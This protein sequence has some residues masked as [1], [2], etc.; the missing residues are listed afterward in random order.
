MCDEDQQ[1]TRR[2]LIQL[3]GLLAGSS[4]CA[5]RQLQAAAAQSSAATTQTKQANPKV[6]IGYI[7]ITDATPLLVAYQNKLFQQQGLD[8]DPPVLFRS[9]A[10]LIEAFLSG[11]VNVIH[12]L[13]PMAVWTRFSSRFPAKV[14][15]W[16]HIAGSALTVQRHINRLEQLGGQYLAIPFWYSVHN[17]VLQAMLRHAGLEVI[18]KPDQKLSRKQVGLIVLSPSD[19]PPALVSAQIAGYLVAEPFNAM[20]E[21]LKIGKILRFSGDVWKQHAC[22]VVF[23][24][25]RDLQQ[26]PEWTQKVVTSIVQAQHWCRQH[27]SA[28]AQLLSREHQPRLTPHIHAVLQQVLHPGAQKYQYYLRHGA[29][30]HRHWPLARIDF[31]PYPFESYTVELIKRMRDTQVEGSR[32]FLDQLDPVQAAR[33]LVDDRFVKKAIHQLG[34]MQAFGLPESFQRQEVFQL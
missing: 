24:H 21:H 26:R 22:C 12:L 34:G 10:Q 9:W 20:A 11:N 16:N 6:R 25:E 15:A 32:V 17:V 2:D 3:M 30:K 8:V 1:Y 33:Q 31:Q 18:T 29:I 5:S 19:M 13:S 4:L 7:P 27:R 14:V 23:M 28:T